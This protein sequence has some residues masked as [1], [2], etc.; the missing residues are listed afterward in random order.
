MPMICVRRSLHRLGPGMGH[1]VCLVTI[2][3]G[4]FCYQLKVAESCHIFGNPV[5]LLSTTS[6]WP[7]LVQLTVI[8]Q[9]VALTC[10]FSVLGNC[11][12]ITNLTHNSWRKSHV[13][14]W[15]IIGQ[16]WLALLDAIR[17]HSNGTCWFGWTDYHERK[18]HS[19]LLANTIELYL[20]PTDLWP[21]LHICLLPPRLT[22]IPHRRVL[23]IGI[24]TNL[25]WWRTEQ[26]TMRTA[27]GCSAIV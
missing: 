18:Q 23:H 6:Y 19:R 21:T 22:G 10:S 2:D 20:L 12:N 26:I 24:W 14:F 16:D 15:R 25:P 5:W 11:V 3:Y 1:R 7:T 9:P 8:T 27:T 17:C 13:R 4:L